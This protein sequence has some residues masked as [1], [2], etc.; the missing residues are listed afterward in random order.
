MTYYRILI[1]ITTALLSVMVLGCAGPTTEK[2]VGF[3][4]ATASPSV[5]TSLCG[6][7]QGSFWYVAGDHTSSGGSLALTLQV[8][9]DSTYTLKRGNRPASSGTV[10]SEG[11]RVILQE[12]SGAR[13]T[14]VRSG[15]K[16][17]GLTKDDLNGRTTMLNLDKQESAPGRFAATGPGC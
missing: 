10:A 16:L 11:N 7:W 17:Y 6:T 12:A 8:A 4:D 9:G 13:V 2:S 1:G 5:P 15:D 14:L 3:A